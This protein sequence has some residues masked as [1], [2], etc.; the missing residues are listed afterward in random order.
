ML[1][2]QLNLKLP[3]TQLLRGYG[4]IALLQGDFEKARAYLQD[5]SIINIEIGNRLGYLWDRVDL[6]YVAFRE[7]NL[8]EARDRFVETAQDFQKDKNTIGVIYTLEGMAGLYVATNKPAIAARLI[9]WTDAERKTIGDTRPV[10]ERA[11]V[12]KIIAACLAK[13]GEV[14][15]SDAYDEG[16]EMSLDEAVAYAL[17]ES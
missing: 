9:G 1:Y 2:Q 3:R 10:L 8:T 7:D 13:M 5:S 11:D 14:A 12:D 17:K 4:Q 16:Q 6:G 15:F